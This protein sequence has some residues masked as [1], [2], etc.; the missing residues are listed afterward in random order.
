MGYFQHDAELEDYRA[1]HCHGCYI[2]E[3][4]DLCPVIH[5]HERQDSNRASVAHKILFEFIPYANNENKK[6]RMYVPA[7]V[8]A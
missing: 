7:E 2:D 6:C 5:A 4:Q 8:T 1:E 3:T